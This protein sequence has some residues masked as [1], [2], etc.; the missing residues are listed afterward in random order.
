[1][2][3]IPTSIKSIPSR[4]FSSCTN[5]YYVDIPYTVTSI[6]SYAFERCLAMPALY[7]PYSVRSVG[8]CAFEGCSKM[9]Q[10]KMDEPVYK[11]CKDTAFK[12]CPAEF[13][14]L[15]FP[16]EG[17]LATVNGL[18][19]KVTD[20]AKYGKG[21]VILYGTAASIS[22]VVVPNVVWIKDCTYKVTKIASKTFYKNT[23][24]Q[25]LYIGSNVKSIGAEAC[26]GCT[27]LTKVSSGAALTTIG[28]KAFVNCKNLST[29][30]ITSKK[31]NKIGTY[32]FYG[33][34]LLKLVN[35]NKTIKLTKAGVKKSL[36][37]SSV[38]TVKV[39]KT[40][41]T[42]YKKIFTKKNAGKKVKVTK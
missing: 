8:E 38:A 23:D 42:A 11:A 16:A 10:I 27:N 28:D 2:F 30:V 18:K 21:T 13:Y 41:V 31:L 24:M 34:S 17:E 5:L 40:K 3:K 22:N 32:A 14:A 15:E 9:T 33:D 26:S 1:M 25:T 20:G 12:N 6:G 36:K 35:I 4:C 19:Y 39:K 7:V 29:F 37:G